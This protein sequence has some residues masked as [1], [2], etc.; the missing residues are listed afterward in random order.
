MQD[1]AARAVLSRTRVSRIVSELRPRV[2]SSATPTRTT[3]E[4]L[5]PPSRLRAAPH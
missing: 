2:W 1:L 3:V 4:R 5:W